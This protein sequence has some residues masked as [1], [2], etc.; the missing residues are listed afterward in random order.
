MGLLPLRHSQKKTEF[1][2]L[3]GL[4]LDVAL[5]KELWPMLLFRSFSIIL[6]READYDQNCDAS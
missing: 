4:S 3:G 2:F 1:A 6:S 5:P